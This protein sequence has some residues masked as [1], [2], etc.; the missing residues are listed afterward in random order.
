MNQCDDL[1]P[2]FFCV[3]DITGFTRLIA[4]AD[5]EFSKEII[6]GLL[7][8]LVDSNILKMNVGEIEGDAIFF[9]RT[10]RL[11]AA[12]RVIK[13]CHL[14]FSTFETYIATYKKSHPEHYE[15]HLADGQLGLK[16]IIHYGCACP[17][18]IKGRTKLIGKDVI[19]A[20]RLLKNSLDENEYIL[21]TEDY[22]RRV[23]R[24]YGGVI[25]AEDWRSGSET[26]EYIGE[27]KYNYLTP[28]EFGRA[29]D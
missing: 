29:E 8:R 6:P 12:A 9:Y 14:F 11:P 25:F 2:A 4:T 10:G 26:Y 3:P 5:I 16:V 7:R 27:V 17:A 23:R 1:L 28:D 13:Q 21:F 22:V 20:H 24:N 18:N 15:K 19:I